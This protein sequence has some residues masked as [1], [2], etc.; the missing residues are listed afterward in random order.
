M[1]EAEVKEEDIAAAA[2][3]VDKESSTVASS[4]DG[5]DE[6]KTVKSML[7]ALKEHSDGTNVMKE[8]IKTF[9]NPFGSHKKDDVYIVD[10][11][12]AL[13]KLKEMVNEDKGKQKETSKKFKRWDFE[14][15]LHEQFERTLDDL[16]VAFLLWGIKDEEDGE[17]Q[18][19]N[20]TKSYRRLETYAD[21][22]LE[23]GTELSEPPLTA[24]SAREAAKP[25]GMK[26]S[27][28]K[29]GHFAWFIDFKAI[30]KVAIKDFTT[31]D[32][33]RMF[34]WYAHFV[35]YHEN[36]QQKGLVFVE[37]VS[38]AG[39]IE[40]MT[41]VPMSLGTKLDRLT[42]GVLPL[43]MKCMYIMNVS[44]WM[45]MFF[46]FMGLFMSKKMKERIVAL[47]DPKEIEEIL[48]KDC[49]PK[50]FGDLEGS[51]EVDLVTAKYFS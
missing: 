24:E 38:K 7:S 37:D 19:F 22:M 27:I 51:M 36:A 14:S 11:D 42:M 30:D 8:S 10:K 29:D 1:P 49:I 33:L 40:S 48:G 32:H 26:S 20:V 28:D 23:H 21:W 2:E 16:F 15:S 4:D 25:W 6:P 39:F 35:M 17:G 41:L 47:K 18:T 9:S 5:G 44:G 45:S 46:S 31:N 50:P 12:E 34:V 3:K 43:K 13:S